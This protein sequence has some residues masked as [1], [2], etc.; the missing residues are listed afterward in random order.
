MWETSSGDAQFS[1]FIGLRQQWPKFTIN[2]L[3]MEPGHSRN[4]DPTSSKPN[5]LSSPP[6][7]VR[8]RLEYPT[9]LLVKQSNGQWEVERMIDKNVRPKYLFISHIGSKTRED[10]EKYLETAKR[11]ADR[12]KFGAIYLDDWCFTSSRQKRAEKMSKELGDAI[13]DYEIYTLCDIVRSSGRV[14]VI[15]PGSTALPDSVTF[16]KEW[17]KRMWTF[18]EGLLAPDKSVLFCPWDYGNGLSV[19]DSS[20]ESL[21][22]IEMTAQCWDIDRGRTQEEGGT[23][24][25]LLAEYFSGLVF[26]STLELLPVVFHALSSRNRGNQNTFSDLA[27]AAMGLLRFRVDKRD[28]ENPTLFQTLAHLSVKNDSDEIIERLISLL[29][30]HR[31]DNDIPLHASDDMVW[32]NLCEPDTYGTLVHHITP[33]CEVVGIA[34]EDQTVFIDNCHAINIRWKDF[35]EVLVSG[36]RGGMWRTITRTLVFGALGVTAL[37][38]QGVLGIILI[39]HFSDMVRSDDG[40]VSSLSLSMISSRA[41]RTSTPTTEKFFVIL[42]IVSLGLG[43]LMAVAIPFISK[44]IF[45]QAFAKCKPCLVGF[46]GVMPLEELERHIFGVV[47]NRLEY[48]PSASRIFTDDDDLDPDNRA[49]LHGKPEWI[50]KKSHGLG[51]HDDKIRKLLM[52]GQRVFTLVDLGEFSVTIFAAERPP[53]VAL[54][55]GREGGMLRAVLCSWDPL[56]DCL[57]KETVVRMPSNVLHSSKPT[58][59]L[60]LCLQTWNNAREARHIAT[61]TLKHAKRAEELAAEAEKSAS[62]AEETAKCAE[63]EVECAREEKREPVV[64]D[65]EVSEARAASDGARAAANETHRAAGRAIAA[66]KSAKAATDIGIAQRCLQIANDASDAA[67]K[68][69]LDTSIC[70]EAAR[71]VA[72]K[73][74]S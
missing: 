65:V 66:V 32:T 36:E 11:L 57:Y 23:S 51:N 16:K 48:S 54:L 46:E 4:Q 44:K 45:A 22:K 63:E 3:D 15:Y 71:K 56:N 28:H 74:S 33:L 35:P 42:T 38:V 12:E 6:L 52:K 8:K 19:S 27:Y 70:A 60:K 61:D 10:K 62:K 59:W 14:A 5:E 58:S 24:T 72:N 43:Y 50:E 29:P 7:D 17:G 9:K 26:M 30:R 40:E 2:K 69:L 1:G 34:E 73:L 41:L 18:L 55:A 13:T 53:S 39:R 31:E 49:Y 64:T 21:N 68:G 37:A 20:I 25:R 67:S 47:V